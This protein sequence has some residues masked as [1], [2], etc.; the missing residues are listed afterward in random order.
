MTEVGLISCEDQAKLQT[1]VLPTYYVSQYTRALPG[2]RVCIITNYI[3]LH[4]ASIIIEFIT[5]STVLRDNIL[6]KCSRGEKG[7]SE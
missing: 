6:M 7:I 5:G 4:K 2:A 1:S 3:E